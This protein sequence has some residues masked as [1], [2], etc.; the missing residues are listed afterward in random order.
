M[1]LIVETGEGTSGAN[2][3]CGLAYASNYLALRNNVTAWDA[4]SRIAREASISEATLYIDLA[5]GHRFFEVREFTNIE[6]FARAFISL[7]SQPNT[8][9]TITIG[10]Q[11]YT[12]TNSVSSANEILIGAAEANTL[13]NIVYAVNASGGTEG[14]E[15]GT[16]TTA[17]AD[18]TAALS[19][20]GVEVVVTAK[21]S[22][23][24]GNEIVIS[25]SDDDRINIDTT[26]L[27]G[28]APQ[29]T[30]PLE[31]PRIQ[32]YDRRGILVDGIPDKLKQATTEYASRAIAASLLPDPEYD[33]SGRIL[34]QSFVK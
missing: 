11:T 14:T 12:F 28:G 3:Y 10:S 18:V 29:G 6:Y 1:G 16:G 23:V 24:D 21:T 31:F 19:D 22:G 5:F 2:A 17:N 13:Q 27:V 4:A 34:E 33:S 15:W 32:L 30:Q 26:T 20:S 7:E 8:N 25:T 9:D